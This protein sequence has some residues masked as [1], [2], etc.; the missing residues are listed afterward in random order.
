MVKWSVCSPSS[1]TIQVLIPLKYTFFCKLL[2]MKIW[3]AELLTFK[4][5]HSVTGE[6]DLFL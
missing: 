3:L 5:T 2:E 4:C 6:C 1:P